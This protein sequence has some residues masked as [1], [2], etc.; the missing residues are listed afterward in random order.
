MDESLK[1]KIYFIKYDK[2]GN[3][4]ERG[5]D[6][7]EYVYYGTAQNSAYKTYPPEEGYKTVVAVRSPWEKYF[8]EVQCGI[9]KCIHVIEETTYGIPKESD[10]MVCDR[11]DIDELGRWYSKHYRFVCPECLAKI[12]E[13]ISCL[14]VV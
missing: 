6:P 5:V 12:R 3:E 13:F 2:D 10:V 9:C 7:R 1:W 11:G 14:E 8:T 4:I